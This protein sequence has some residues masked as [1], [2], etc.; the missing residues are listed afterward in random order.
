MNVAKL[1]EGEKAEE[2]IAEPKKPDL[3]TVRVDY[4]V[5]RGDDLVINYQPYVATVGAAA[6]E[7][8]Q[9]KIKK[10]I[11][12]PKF[13]GY[14]SATPAKKYN[15]NY[16]FVKN[17]YGDDKFKTHEEKKH[18]NYGIEY[19][20]DTEYIY[21]PDRNKIKVRHIFQHLFNREKY[22]YNKGEEANLSDKEKKALDKEKEANALK[23]DIVTEQDGLTG[24][25]MKVQALQG[26]KIE[27]YEP[28]VNAIQTQVPENVENFELIFRYNRK[29]YSLIYD[30]KDGTPIPSRTIYY[31]QIIPKLEVVEVPKKVGGVF[32]GWK[33]STDL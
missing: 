26:D 21:N 13:D 31:Q 28:E 14:T 5:K 16:N 2:F 32:Q 6:T 18:D 15:V 20:S 19:K 33:P 3:H 9:A 8:E 4:K 24:T 27:G 25:S 11:D 22:G 1:K 10:I 17:A 30:S 12:L 7:E 29:K 23:E